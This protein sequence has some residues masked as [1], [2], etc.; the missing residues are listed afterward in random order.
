MMH[1]VKVTSWK[2]FS[3]D[4]ES[5]KCWAERDGDGIRLPARNTRNIV[6][7]ES[8]R[9][10]HVQTCI[11]ISIKGEKRKNNSSRFITI[12]MALPENRYTWSS[13]AR[14][15]ISHNHI[16]HFTEM[17]LKK[18][19]FL[20]SN[21][22]RCNKL[23]AGYCSIWTFLPRL[24][25]NGSICVRLCDEKLNIDYL[26]HQQ[27]RTPRLSERSCAWKVFW[28]SLFSISWEEI[29]FNICISLIDSRRENISWTWKIGWEFSWNIDAIIKQFVNAPSFRIR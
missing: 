11:C 28:S 16:N 1:Q 10:F 17:K 20:L 4:N 18:F 9:Q 23:Q 25:N 24:P 3:P 27:Q 8:S 14:H 29:N 5:G 26:M 22:H 7:H 15:K 13:T 19:L 6:L 21:I 2:L 12:S